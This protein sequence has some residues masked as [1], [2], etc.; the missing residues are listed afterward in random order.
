MLE[1]LCI[2]FWH[3]FNVEQGEEEDRE[4]DWYN[5]EEDSRTR[6]QKAQK[7]QATVP[8][9]YNHSQHNISGL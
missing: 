3:L 2:V 8:V 6:R 4:D 9:T 7:I 5:D 1:L